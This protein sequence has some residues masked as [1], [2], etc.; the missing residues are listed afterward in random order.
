MDMSLQSVRLLARALAGDEAGPA[1]QHAPLHAAGPR[2]V[3]PTRFTQQ[4]MRDG[5]IV[6]HRN[7]TLDEASQ[8]VIRQ[9]HIEANRQKKTKQREEM[10]ARDLKR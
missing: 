6:H 9:K 2:H 3:R 5:A 1:K 10:F 8:V 4:F 7:T